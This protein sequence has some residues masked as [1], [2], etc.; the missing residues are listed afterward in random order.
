MHPLITTLAPW[1]LMIHTPR[2]IGP[3]L[4]Y[5]GDKE[6]DN[7]FTRLRRKKVSLC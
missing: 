4:R 2:A 7:S 1:S 5:E 6:G 3:L